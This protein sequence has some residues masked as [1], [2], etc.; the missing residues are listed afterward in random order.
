MPSPRLSREI[1]TTVAANS[2]AAREASAST[3]NYGQLCFRQL[4][5]KQT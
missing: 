4:W 2:E 3:Q 5:W 1:T